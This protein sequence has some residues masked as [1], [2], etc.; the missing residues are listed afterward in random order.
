MPALLAVTVILIT[1]QLLI[2]TQ[3]FWLPPLCARSA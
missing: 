1:S 3:H 2:G